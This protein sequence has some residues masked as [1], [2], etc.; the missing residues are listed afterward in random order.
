MT[1]SSIFYDSAA[2]TV[3]VVVLLL[4]GYVGL[5]RQLRKLSWLSMISKDP[6]S[7]PPVIDGKYHRLQ[8]IQYDVPS[9]SGGVTATDGLYWQLNQ[10]PVYLVHLIRLVIILPSRMAQLL[11]SKLKYGRYGIQSEQ[12]VVD[13]ILGVPCLYMMCK[14]IHKT[15]VN[16][17]RHAVVNNTNNFNTNANTTSNNS[18]DDDKMWLFE[19]PKELPGDPFE[20]SIV[21]SNISIL[22]LQKERHIVC[23]TYEGKD[24]DPKSFSNMLFSIVV[25][26]L[27]NWSHFKSHLMAETSA[28]E[29]IDSGIEA[30]EPSA[31]FVHGLH[32][33]LLN[34]PLSPGVIS[35]PL[36][37]LSVT[38][39]CFE[40]RVQV[41]MS[42]YLDMKKRSLPGFDFLFAAR[43][44][45]AKH[46]KAHDLNVSIEPLFQNIAVHSI[47]HYF[48]YQFLAHHHFSLDGSETFMSYIRSLI[49]VEYWMPSKVNP[50][51]DVRLC[52]VA[53]SLGNHPF[54]LDVYSDLKGADPVLAEH[55]L[56]STSF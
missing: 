6:K 1:M 18:G 54:Y 8:D 24:I 56:A 40:A 3:I 21:L 27:N 34:N 42:H 9:S 29:I 35:S 52:A 53:Q 51:D 43:K 28:Q 15:E 26:T 23:A 7:H 20:G 17:G 45:I 55:V 12:D 49:F 50:L 38:R 2:T 14:A 30:L 32:S 13:L 41:P 11:L 4:S 33:G 44:S 16:F 46:L 39:E 31:R 19:I 5:L 36:Y 10:Y 47:D 37:G 22:I 25:A 48:M